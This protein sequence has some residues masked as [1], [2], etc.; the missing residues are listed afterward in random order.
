MGAKTPGGQPSGRSEG[1]RESALDAFDN[2]L[3][4]IAKEPEWGEVGEWIGELL[5]KGETFDGT[6]VEGRWVW[7]EVAA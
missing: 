1:R 6:L 2:R 3:A 7:K 5:R 4:A